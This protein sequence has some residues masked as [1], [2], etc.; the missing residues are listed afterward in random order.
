[1]DA[2]G[3]KNLVK[4]YWKNLDERS[5]INLC[6]AYPEKQKHI[7]SDENLSNFLEGR[8]PGISKYKNPKDSWEKFF[9]LLS[10]YK[11][12][13]FEEFGYTYKGGDFENQYRIFKNSRNWF[14]RLSKAVDHNEY[15]IVKFIIDKFNDDSV[16]TIG[17]VE[18]AINNQNF[19]MFKLLIDKAKENTYFIDDFLN[20]ALAFTARHGNLE[21]LKYLVEN[22][23]ADLHA[24]DERALRVASQNGHLDIVK[25]LVERG[26]DVHAMFEGAL[27]FAA[28][29]GHQDVVNYLL[30]KGADPNAL[31]ED[32]QGE[33]PAPQQNVYYDE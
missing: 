3:D 17:L 8:Y 27:R 29:R 19:P 24:E 4:M 16:I 12:K 10:L 21:M 2:L 7:C 9:L 6:K 22:K 14:D 28:E 20:Q 1:M 23:G 26:A 33:M 25:Y 5:I 32:I 11:G 30:S 13:L 15:D 18:T 31:D